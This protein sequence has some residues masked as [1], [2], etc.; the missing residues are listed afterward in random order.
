MTQFINKKS[1]D[2]IFYRVTKEATS[3]E[4]LITRN[5]NKT[6]KKILLDNNQNWALVFKLNSIILELVSRIKLNKNKLEFFFPEYSQG[7]IAYD[8]YK[9][10]DALTIKNRIYHS[11]TYKNGW[12]K[13]LWGEDV[14]PFAVKWN[15]KEYV[16]YCSGIANP[17]DAKFFNGERIL[18]REITN[19]KIF[20]GYIDEEGYNDP[21]IINIIKNRKDDFKLKTLLAILNSKLATFYHFN[22]SPKATKGAFPKI[23]V[24]DIKSFPL[25]IINQNIQIIII[26]I[27]DKIIA[28][29]QNNEDSTHNEN[30]IDNMVYELYELTEEEIKLVEGK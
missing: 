9:G 22:S 2:L 6:S 14:T 17:R 15:K 3:F 11:T 20:A 4:D 1:E 26:Q 24:E 18:V 7:L 19:P 12:K 30:L 16:N 29:K 10:Q 8:K 23:L 27:V 13:W 5:L 21:A 28:Q 25:P